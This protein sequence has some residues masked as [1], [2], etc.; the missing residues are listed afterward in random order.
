[1][2]SLRFYYKAFYETLSSPL[3]SA[4]N[5]I[6]EW[7]SFS[8]DALRAYIFLIP[9]E[10]KDP[11]RCINYRPIV[12]LNT[13]L[14]LFAKVLA[15]R[16]LPY[17]PSPIHRDQAGFVPLPEPRDN[18]IW[19]INLIHAAKSSNR[20][21]LLLSTDAENAFD[22]VNWAFIRATL[23]HIG[24]GSSMLSWILS[25][26]SNPLAAGKDNETRSDF[27]NITIGT[28]QGCPLSPL[29]FIL[30]LEPFL[31][32]VRA[33]LDIAG[34]RKSLGSHIVA[35]FADDLIFFLTDL[36]TSL[37]NLL[38]SLQD[39]GAL[40]FFVRQLIQVCCPKHYSRQRHGPFSA[41]SVSS[42][43]GE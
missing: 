20:P 21:L 24:L 13:N 17:V 23:E 6:M 3:I 9:K 1:M 22:R 8:I 36:L 43:L 40:S 41:F 31:C 32:T 16:L 19:V 28:R 10:G 37:P 35:E 25:L 18:T 26:Y 11:L 33:D 29:I 34:Y 12:L 30:S 7:K 42:P 14:K 2:A 4:L 5:S 39:Y 27:F 38:Q 15:N